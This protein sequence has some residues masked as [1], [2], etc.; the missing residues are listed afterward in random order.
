MKAEHKVA[1][2]G[3]FE[4]WL[5]IT[6]GQ[7]WLESKARGVFEGPPEPFQ[8]GGSEHV[9]GG[10]EAVD[11]AELGHGL[12]EQLAREL[13]ALVGDEVFGRGEGLGGGLEEL[14]RGGGVGLLVVG[15]R[16]QQPRRAGVYE[17]SQRSRSRLKYMCRGLWR[18][19]LRRSLTEGLPLSAFS[20][21]SF[22]ALRL[23]R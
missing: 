18:S 6:D 17:N 22:I 14:G 5:Q 1:G 12:P 11:D 10:S 9:L 20:I 21:A 13:S 15:H 8:A 4:P 2:E 23:L 3:G 19:S 16:L 7:G